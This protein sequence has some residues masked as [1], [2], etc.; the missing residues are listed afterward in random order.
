MLTAES[1]DPVFITNITPLLD[2]EF[3]IE[4]VSSKY[5]NFDI[6]KEE[7]QYVQSN[8]T[9]KESADQDER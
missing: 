7:V 6:T 2:G 9:D 4:T 8:S 3:K 1:A 5:M